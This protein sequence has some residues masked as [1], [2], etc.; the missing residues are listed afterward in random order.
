MTDEPSRAPRPIID[1]HHHVWDTR[2][3]YHP[4]LRDEPMIPF[5]YGDYSAIRRDFLPEDYQRA[6]AGH[7]IVGTIT[8][9]AEWR[10]DDLAAEKNFIYRLDTG[11]IPVLGHVGRV[12]LH[13]DDAPELMQRHGTSDMV[14]GIRHK[15]AVIAAPGPLPWRAP[16]SMSDPAWRRGYAL[17]DKYALHFE[18]QA[19][20]WH[21]DELIDLVSAFPGIPV[22]IN[23]AFLPADRSPEGLAG[24][25]A[26]LRRAASAPQVSIKISGLGIEGRPWS[27]DDN[28][29]VIRNA[30]EAFGPDRCM[31]A[32]NFPVDGL[33][34]TFDTIY[35]GF[36]TATADLPAGDRRKLFAGNASRVYKVAGPDNLVRLQDSARRR[37]SS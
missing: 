8:V 3:N 4:C 13:R 11:T 34:G 6:S 5:R 9:E 35:S 25:R 7:R 36:K 28:R 24:W 22:V 21:V 1:A 2:R 12:I 19:P 26:A 17:L 20:W 30:I 14:R 37:L 10:E 18:L 31:F 23:H 16:G 32:S 29:G 33:V 27:L 15:P